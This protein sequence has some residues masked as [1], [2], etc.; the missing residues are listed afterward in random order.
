MTD[1]KIWFVILC[2]GIG[3]YL[4]RFS[5]VGIMGARPLPG[6]LVRMLR[7]VPVAV[8]PAL[9]APLAV[10]PAATGGETDPARIAAAAAALAVGAWRRNVI[11]SVFCG[12]CVLYLMLWLRT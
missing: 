6:W 11:L 5:F 2:L 12:L 8:L 3:T 9:T 4:I 7:F 10:W 1:L